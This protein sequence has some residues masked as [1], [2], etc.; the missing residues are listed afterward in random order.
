M[1]STRWDAYHDRAIEI[2]RAADEQL[3]ALLAECRA[4]GDFP[5]DHTDTFGDPDNSSVVRAERIGLEVFT[6]MGKLADHLKLEMTAAEAR[7]VQD[8]S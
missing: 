1:E 7:N 6:L 8:H 3:K 5:A 2:A 4:S